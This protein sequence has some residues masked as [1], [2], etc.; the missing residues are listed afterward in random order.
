MKLLALR[1]PKA[2]VLH[3]V[4]ENWPVGIKIDPLGGANQ[5][6][7]PSHLGPLDQERASQ[8]WCVRFKADP[9]TRLPFS[10]SVFL[11]GSFAP[12]FFRA[13]GPDGP[14]FSDRHDPPSQKF[15]TRVDEDW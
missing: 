12:Q 1:K 6:H 13:E 10:V 7:V 14:E 3:R 9:L 8:F 4:E 11:S 15:T 5:G 2:L